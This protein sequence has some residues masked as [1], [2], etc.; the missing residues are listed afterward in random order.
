MT[1]PCLRPRPYRFFYGQALKYI[2]GIGE[3]RHGGIFD[4]DG[5]FLVDRRGDI[6]IRFVLGHGVG[7]IGRDV[8]NDN[9]LPCLLYT[10]RCV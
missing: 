2:F 10:S 4:R 8:L 9:F 3:R 1:S 6:A 7:D 5:S